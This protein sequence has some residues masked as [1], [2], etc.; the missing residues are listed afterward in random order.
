M[1]NFFTLGDRAEEID[2]PARAGAGHCVMSDVL[3]PAEDRGCG[4][5]FEARRPQL[6]VDPEPIAREP[7]AE[8]PSRHVDRSAELELMRAV[9]AHDPRAEAEL[10]RRIIGLVRGRARALTRNKADVDDSS[11]TA[12]VEILRCAG[13][14]RGDGT[15]AGWCERIAVRTILRQQRKQARAS[16]AID[17]AVNPDDVSGTIPEP[18]IAETIPGGEVERYL[19]ELSEDRHKALV[20][21]H[22]LGHSVEEIAEQTGVSPNTVKDR[23]RMARKQV[24]QSIRQREVIAAAKRRNP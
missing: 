19:L 22:V 7:V 4:T 16:A 2:P 1:V 21:R 9:A 5:P 6:V 13:N 15:L 11:Q 20:L 23:L 12:M 24:R 3:S 17:A 10:V 14:Y 18:G 8:L